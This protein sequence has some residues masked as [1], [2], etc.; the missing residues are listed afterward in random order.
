MVTVVVVMVM[1]LQIVK[2]RPLRKSRHGTRRRRCPVLSVQA[3]T[4][5][6]RGAQGQATSPANYI[7]A[8]ATTAPSAAAGI[9]KLH[10]VLVWQR[11]LLLV[12]AVPKE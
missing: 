11:L 10:S 4:V 5:L 12:F 7:D 2:R 3:T 6:S 8:D 1:R 9:V